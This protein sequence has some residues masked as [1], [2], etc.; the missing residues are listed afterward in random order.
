MQ[1]Q[2]RVIKNYILSSEPRIIDDKKTH[3]KRKNI[4][5]IYCSL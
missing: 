5:I 2:N 1:K 3:Q 4:K